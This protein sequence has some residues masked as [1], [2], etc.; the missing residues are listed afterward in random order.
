ME[1]FIAAY[2]FERYTLLISSTC[3]QVPLGWQDDVEVMLKTLDELPR[4]IRCLLMIDGILVDKDG[5]LVV[6]LVACM[7]LMPADGMQ[8]IRDAYATAKEA[9]KKR[10]VDCGA[11]GILVDAREGRRVLCLVCQDKRGI[12]CHGC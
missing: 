1:S 5:D 6:S 4:A 7:H 8:R 11:R 12:Q 2:L 10:C 3:A 9:V